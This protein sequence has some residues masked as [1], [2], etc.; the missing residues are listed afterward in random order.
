[1]Q[2][3]GSLVW[4][5]P[6]RLFHWALA[7]C[8]AGSWIT[9][10]AGFEWTDWHF[11]LGY[12]SLTLVG[13]RL[14]WGLFGTDHARFASFLH[15]PAKTLASLRQVFTRTP[16]RYPGHTPVGGWSV[17]LML[18]LVA[19]QAG[20]GLFI[21]DDIFWAGPYN[22]VVSS[23]T[24]GKLAQIHHINFTLLQI[25]VATHIAAIAWYRYG[26]H[27]RLVGPMLHGRKVLDNSADA[28]ASSR[29]PRALLLFVL[30]AAAV[31]ALIQLAPA[32]SADIYSF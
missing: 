5:L 17:V 29:W 11:R 32:P 14:L 2:Q 31:T 7:L 13:F 26:K 10:E 4:D 9:A 30:M 22:S 21:S 8:L 20:T 15:G 18:M 28:I 3:R 24:A 27:T 23:A 25:T 12:A 6:S 19:V 16:S 1:M